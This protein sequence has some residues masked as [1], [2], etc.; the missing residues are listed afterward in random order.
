MSNNRSDKM[1]IGEIRKLQALMPKLFSI[2]DLKV[3]EGS[4]PFEDDGFCEYEG[5]SKRY[6]CRV[7]VRPMEFGTIMGDRQG[8]PWLA[9]QYHI[10]YPRPELKWDHP[11]NGILY[12]DIWQSTCRNHLACNG[13]D[14]CH[15]FYKGTAEEIFK[16][17]DNHLFGMIGFAEHNTDPDDP[18][19]GGMRKSRREAIAAAPATADRYVYSKS[20]PARQYG[21]FP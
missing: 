14:N 5:H 7:T 12:R 4:T 20:D 19:V 16:V 13:K 2:W 10:D 15:V 17:F 9:C 3:I 8:N 11:L 21:Y 6:D 18:F 1:L